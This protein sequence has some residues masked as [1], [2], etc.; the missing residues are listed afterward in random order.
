M[1]LAQ[2]HKRPAC[3]LALTPSFFLYIFPDILLSS[4]PPRQKKEKKKKK[5]EI[6]VDKSQS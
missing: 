4:L 3:L 1:Y 6:T 2:T 5:E